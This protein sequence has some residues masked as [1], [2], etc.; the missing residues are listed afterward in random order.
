MGDV[1]SGRD[2]GERAV[3][4]AAENALRTLTPA[5]GKCLVRRR[6]QNEVATQTPWVKIHGHEAAKAQM[7]AAIHFTRTRADNGLRRVTQGKTLIGSE[8]LNQKD[9]AK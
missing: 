3:Q 9:G 5:E 4:E 6:K 1:G 2:R 8:Y 7:L